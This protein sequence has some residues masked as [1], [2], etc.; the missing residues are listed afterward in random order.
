MFTLHFASLRVATLL[1]LAPLAACTRPPQQ[2]ATTADNIGALRL[3][4]EVIIPFNQD[5]RGTKFGGISGL[6]RAPDGTWYLI[7]D[8]KGEFSPARFYTA[9]LRYDAQGFQGVDITGVH[10]LQSP[11]ATATPEY[12]DP[13]SIRYSPRTHALFYTS[14]GS[15]LLKIDPFVREMDTTG[16]YRR[17]LPLPPMFRFQ[18]QAAGVG[19]HQNATFESMATTPDGRSLWV[20]MEGALKQDRPD[21][22]P[23]TAL[24]P[25]RFSQFDSRT[26]ALRR[27][28]VYELDPVISQGHI[29]RNAELVAVSD[30]EFLALE[31]SFYRGENR[32]RVYDVDT[33][34]ATDV[35]GQPTLRP[36]SYRPVRK[37]LIA[38][39]G[40]LGRR[41][42]NIE[43]LAFGPNLPNG[44]R[45][46]VV[47]SDNNFNPD[48]ISQFWAFEV[49]P[50]AAAQ[51]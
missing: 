27:Q 26:G 30:T 20:L 8:D 9:R 38:D 6:D 40:K 32:V 47:V 4:G 44:H 41:L 23:A 36:G 51:P 33:Q 21:D 15:E 24:Y 50:T 12:M 43:G 34:G 1:A 46:L 35:S 18:G 31:C 22:A 45:T 17:T 48:E 10:Y 25:N 19:P 13:E 3:L 2:P 49:L 42:D 29:N 37:R 39:F 7:S 5:V 11:T 28:L 16:V 14:E